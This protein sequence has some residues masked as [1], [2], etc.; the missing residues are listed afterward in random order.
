MS[1]NAIY[2]MFDKYS[3]NLDFVRKNTARLITSNIDNVFLCPICFDKFFTRNDIEDDL[4]SREHVPP[5]KLSGIVRTLTCKACNNRDGSALD[6]QLKQLIHFIEFWQ[7]TPKSKLDVMCS[8]NDS[9]HLPA[10]LTHLDYNAI[11]LEGHPHRTNPKNIEKAIEHFKNKGNEGVKINFSMKSH[12]N[13]FPESALLR[14]AYLY[15]FSILGYSFLINPN[16]RV[17]RGQIIHPNEEVL[18][19]WGITS[20]E[21]PDELLGVNLV[22]EPKELRSYFVVFDLVTPLG[23][24]TRWGVLLPGSTNPGLNIYRWLSQQGDT[25]FQQRVI[26]IPPDLNFVNEPLA[27]YE[28]WNEWF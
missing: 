23:N 8:V 2:A 4:L 13:R 9:P 14:I 3:Q 5:E 12:K 16:L 7:D 26:P 10:T 18:P 17:V 20:Y 15:A 21:I 24:K 11:V 25:P 28:I 1:K 19:T 22:V 6:S 27:T